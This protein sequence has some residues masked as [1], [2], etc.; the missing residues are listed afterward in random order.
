MDK[1]AVVEKIASAIPT[2]KE[3]LVDVCSHQMKTMLKRELARPP[4]AREI[5]YDFFFQES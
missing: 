5:K 4:T 3:L 2:T 1:A